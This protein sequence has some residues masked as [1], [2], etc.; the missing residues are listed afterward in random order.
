[1]YTNTETKRTLATD[2]NWAQNCLFIKSNTNDAVK[3]TDNCKNF[4][5]KHTMLKFCVYPTNKTVVM[6]NNQGDNQ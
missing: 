2:M 3:E 6:S 1:M 4:K 5:C